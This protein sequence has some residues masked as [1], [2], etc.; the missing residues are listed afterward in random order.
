MT[1]GVECQLRELGWEFGDDGPLT[2]TAVTRARSP[3]MCLGVSATA[4]REERKWPLLAD[5]ARVAGAC[6][7][8]HPPPALPTCARYRPYAI[9]N[10]ADDTRFSIF[11]SPFIVASSIVHY[12]NTPSQVQQNFVFSNS[13]TYARIKET[14][15]K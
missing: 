8:P 3:A 14:H 9:R 12:L 6:A 10:V 1:P 2:Y 13:T 11:S 4:A 5:S 7:S 15:S